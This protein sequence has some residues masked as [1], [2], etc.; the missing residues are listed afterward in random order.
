[1]NKNSFG[2]SLRLTLFGESHGPAVGVV[3]DGL[4]AGVPIDEASIRREMDKRRAAGSLA[5]PRREADEVEFL[6]GVYGGFS[7]GAPLCLIVRNLDTK[8]A[9]YTNISHIPRP[10]HADYASFVRYQGYNDPRGGGHF[11]GRLT[12]PLVAAGAICRSLL[13]RHG[14]VLGT[15]LAVCAGIEDSPLPTEENALRTALSG[16]NDRHFAVLDEAAGEKMRAAILA[17]KEAGDSVG[18]ILETA[19][20]G[21]APGLGEPFFSSIE[22]VL[23]SLFFSIPAVKGLEFGLG[24]GFADLRGSEANDAFVLQGKRVLTATNHNGGINGGLSNGMPLVLRAVVKPTPSISRP[25]A[26]VDLD[27]HAETTLCIKG[28][29]D[30]CILPR[31]RAVADAVTAIGLVDLLCQRHGSAWQMSELA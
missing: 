21:L 6:S 27:T 12:A 8:S 5:T 28:R 2:V 22:S 17:A 16:L 13:S 24:F 14:I 25:Q 11:S 4:C 26:S 10:G 19:V 20:L 3:L 31:A 29:H 23:S 15:H 1:M 30:P 18:G 9:D 7:T